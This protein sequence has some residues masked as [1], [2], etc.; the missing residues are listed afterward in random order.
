M[1]VSAA[2]WAVGLLSLQGAN[3]NALVAKRLH[4][5]AERGLNLDG[6]PMKSSNDILR[7]AENET[8]PEEYAKLPLDHFAENKNYDYDG[9]FYNRF[10]VREKGY[11]PGAPVFIYDV[12]ETSADYYVKTR[13]QDPNDPFRQI[14]DKYNGLAILWEHRYYGNST[15]EMILNTTPPEAFRWLKSDQALA[16]IDYFAKQFKRKNIACDLTPKSVPWVMVGASYPGVRGALMRERYPKTIYAAFAAS[17]PVQAKTDFRSYW[18]PVYDG[19][20]R[21]GWG[22]C[23]RDVQAVIRYVDRLMDKGYTPEVFAIKERFLGLGGGNVSNPGFGDIFQLPFFQWQNFGVE[24]G[25]P[26]LRSF[27][28]W[29][30]TDPTTNKTSGAAG[31]AKSKGV[32]FSI[33]RWISW[34][35]HPDTVNYGFGINCSFSQTIPGENCNL[36]LPYPWPGYM[37]WIW[38]FCTEWGYFQTANVGPKQLG[39]K[40]SDLKRWYSVCHRQWPTATWKEHGFPEYPRTDGTNA[41]FGGWNIRPSNTFWSG[42]EFDP[43]RVL[44]PLSNAPF[45]P[46]V[47][48]FQKPPRCGV[49]QKRSE[50]FGYIQPNE[51]HSYEFKND[52][53]EAGI[54]TRKLFTVALDQWLK[55]FVARKY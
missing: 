16:D 13:L 35:T 10:W 7:R 20:Q 34:P 30:S 15:P 37:P 26:G 21:F 27:C 11:K 44:S 54:A 2:V 36:D 38:Q 24:G 45:A 40:F 52:R 47:Y 18:D 1:M 5:L 14:V 22:N 4:D 12:G 17:A 31:W 19:L 6:S 23:T 8:I 55:C 49:R 43:F 42:G 53:P 41:K 39:S 28:D 9:Y 51:T 32:D 46:P 3:A 48:E 25:P 29:M 50:I 33:D